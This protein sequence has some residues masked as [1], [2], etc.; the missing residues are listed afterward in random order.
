MPRPAPMARPR[1][2]W[3]I[4]GGINTSTGGSGCCQLGVTG[5]TRTRSQDGGV[6][7]R[8]CGELPCAR[9]YPG[10]AHS[11]L[12]ICCRGS[13][14]ALYMCSARDSTVLM[15]SFQSRSAEEDG[16][17]CSSRDTTRKRNYIPTHINVHVPAH[18]FKAWFLR[19]G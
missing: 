9:S 19:K 6:S 5:H 3:E 1:H 18:I 2:P 13:A 4:F 15:I 17:D 7:T 11:Y 14:F 8:A 10:E 12:R 16:H